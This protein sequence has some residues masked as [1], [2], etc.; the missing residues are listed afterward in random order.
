MAPVF[1]FGAA[2]VLITAGLVLKVMPS[3]GDVVTHEVGEDG[4]LAPTDGTAG[5]EPVQVPAGS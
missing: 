2:V 4:Y 3:R 5:N 1:W